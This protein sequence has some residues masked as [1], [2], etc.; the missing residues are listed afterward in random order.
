MALQDKIISREQRLQEFFLMK[1]EIWNDLRD[2]MK[3][4]LENNETVMKSKNCDNRDWYAG[5]CSGIQD[6]IDLEQRHNG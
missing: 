3:E 6:I 1:P 4:I 2:S 5:K